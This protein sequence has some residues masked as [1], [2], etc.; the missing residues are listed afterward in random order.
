MVF[1]ALSL[2][3]EIF[4]QTCCSLHVLNG[5]NLPADISLHIF[6]HFSFILTKYWNKTFKTFNTEICHC[7]ILY[8][9]A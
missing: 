5:V 6:I 8:N 2:Q 1:R 3:L 4:I 9:N 7:T